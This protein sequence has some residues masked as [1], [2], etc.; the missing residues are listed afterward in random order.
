MKIISAAARSQRG[1]RLL[2]PSPISTALSFNPVK[3]ISLIIAA[4]TTLAGFLFLV[5]AA[6][7]TLPYTNGD[8]II[9]FRATGGS[10]F[11][12]DYEANLGNATIF[13]NAG[14]TVTPSIGNIK[15]DL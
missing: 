2:L 3:L 8:L 15:A 9:G 4:C 7:A 14:G 12:T 10:G 11:S 5:P 6:Q 1:H 13:L